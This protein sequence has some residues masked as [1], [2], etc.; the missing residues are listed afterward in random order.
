MR[1]PATLRIALQQSV[2]LQAHYARLLN[3]HDGGQRMIFET[4]E[5]LVER[6][7]KIGRFDN[8]AKEES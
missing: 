3:M 7:R 5:A 1:N 6:L 4:S 8:V 2:S